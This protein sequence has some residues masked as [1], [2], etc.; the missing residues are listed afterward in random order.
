MTDRDN[1]MRRESAPVETEETA[2]RQPVFPRTPFTVPVQIQLPREVHESAPL[3]YSSP[4]RAYVTSQPVRERKDPDGNPV[5]ETAGFWPRATAAL[6][7]TLISAVLWVILAGVIRI[8][9][10]RLDEPFFFQV[11]LIVVLFYL[12]QKIYYIFTQWKF[13]KTLG[14]TALR[15]ALV[16][17]ETYGRPDLWTVFFRETFGK[18]LSVISGIGSLLVFGKKHLPLHDRL[19][20]TEVIY[21][22][23]V[24]APAAQTDSEQEKPAA[25]P[26]AAV[27]EEKTSEVVTATLEELQEAVAYTAEHPDEEVE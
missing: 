18:F 26:E 14:K 20:D 27:Q 15:L 1:D 8:F 22:M 5:G 24:P 9:S 19:A 10:D 3:T 17:S 25:E 21:S 6:I 16:S 7:D 12:A 4:Y 23:G 11:K 2:E 13:G